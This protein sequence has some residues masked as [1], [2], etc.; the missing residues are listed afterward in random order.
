MP[1]KSSQSHYER[2]IVIEL[3]GPEDDHDWDLLLDVGQDRDDP[4]PNGGLLHV[5][6]APRHHVD[7]QRG[8]GTGRVLET[9][10]DF[11]FVRKLAVL[12]Y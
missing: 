9:A 1:F 11:G 8:G 6:P 3:N 4:L 2:P 10:A 7:P 5:L 12:Q